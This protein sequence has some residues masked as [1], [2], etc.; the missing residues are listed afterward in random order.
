MTGCE[1][2][3]KAVRHERA[4]RLPIDGSATPESHVALERHVD[5][6]MGTSWRKEPTP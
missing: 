1:R 5:I 6:A 4:D 2:V 3:V